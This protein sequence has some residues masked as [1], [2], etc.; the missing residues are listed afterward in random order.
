MLPSVE[1][2]SHKTLCCVTGTLLSLRSPGLIPEQIWADANIPG[3]SLDGRKEAGKPEEEDDLGE[4][5]G[6]E[7]RDCGKVGQRD[8]NLDKRSG[9]EVHI[10]ADVVSLLGAA[11]PPPPL[12]PP[13]PWRHKMQSHSDFT[14]PP[15]RLLHGLIGRNTC[16]LPQK[17]NLKSLSPCFTFRRG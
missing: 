11:A 15:V 4:N 14:P 9:E 6:D 10:P 8:G 17:C 5:G 13:T 3:P 16:L 12:P 7:W 2:A 1:S